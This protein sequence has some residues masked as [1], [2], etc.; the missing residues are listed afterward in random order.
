[1]SRAGYLLI[2][3]VS[4]FFVACANNQKK[5]LEIK[6]EFVT[7][8]EQNGLKLFS[9]TV[10]M[11]MPEGRSSGKR[12]GGGMR[13]SGMGGGGMG[14]VG[15]RGGGGMGSGGMRGGGMKG[16]RMDGG[17][18]RNSAKPDREAMM[19]RFK[20]VVY[21]KLETKLSETGYCRES[22]MELDNYFVR[23]RSQI[24]GECKDSATA[25][26]RMTFIND[27]NTQY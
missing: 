21:E 7:K 14:G 4:L 15:M 27:E 9:Y 23:G 18:M 10:T 13:G 16:G 20:K 22:Y 24:R 5:A 26:D 19:N 17:G 1:M 11:A 8:I 12:S 25:E 2:F 6:E 3:I